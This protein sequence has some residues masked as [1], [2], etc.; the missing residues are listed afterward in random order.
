MAYVRAKRFITLDVLSLAASTKV[1]SKPLILTFKGGSIINNEGTIARLRMDSVVP[2]Q[3]RM[4]ARIEQMHEDIATTVGQFAAKRL[5][6][7]V[8]RPG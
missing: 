2:L 7:H 3:S 1:K 4:S 8:P 6:R 5:R